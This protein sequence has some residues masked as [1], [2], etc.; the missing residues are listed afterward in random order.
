[1]QIIPANYSANFDNFLLT[2]P[3]NVREK[4]ASVIGG[5][6]LYNAGLPNYPYNFTRDS[7]L[8][9]ILMKDPVMLREQLIFSSLLQGDAKNPYTGEE[10]GKI[11]HQMPGMRQ[12]NL[13]TEYNACDTTA[14]FLYGH[15]IYLDLTNDYYF[16]ER[17]KSI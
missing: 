13:S 12:S 5:I 7:I 8:S 3:Q 16:I 10:P 15:E 9:G 6:T 4:L 14:L 17:Q 2:D 11:F 1:M